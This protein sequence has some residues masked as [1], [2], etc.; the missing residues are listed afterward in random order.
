MSLILDSSSLANQIAGWTS[1]LV[2]IVFLRVIIRFG[3][4]ASVATVA[5][6]FAVAVAGTGAIAVAVVVART[7]A[8]AVAGV[9][10]IAGTFAIAGAFA[11][12]VAVAFAIARAFAVAGVFV[13]AVAFAIVG[14]FAVAGGYAV[15]FAIVFAVVFFLVGTYIAWRALQGEEKF[16]SIRNF[17]IAIAAFQGTSFHN[18][19]LTD[20]NFSQATLKSTNFCK[21]KLTRTCLQKVKML[22]RVRAGTT[23]LKHAKLRQVLITG[24]GQEKKFDNF[25]LR[26]VNLKGANL[27]DASFVS[28]DLS[29]ANLQDADL[30]RAKLVKT[31]LDGT[32]FTGST[33]T[34]AYIEDWGIT[35]KTK[36][37]GVKCEY[38]YMKLPTKDNPDPLRKPDNRQEV[39]ADGEFGDF[40][41]PIFDTLDLYHNHGV[42]PRAIAISLKQLA[43]DNPQ[44]ELQIVG[45]E[46]KGENNFLLRAK[47]A[48][49]TDKSE[50]SAKYFETYNQLKNLPAQ[51]MKLLLAEQ[52]SRIVNLENMVQTALYSSHYYAVKTILILAANPKT[53]SSLRLDEE[54]REIDAGLQR[55]KK[56]EQFDLKQRWAVRIRDVSQA[57]LDFKPRIVHFSGHG[58]GDDGLVLEDEMGNVQLVDGEA[59][60]ELFKLFADHVECVLLNACYSEVQALAIVKYIPYVIGMNWAIGDKASIEFAVGFYSAL[61]AGE[62]IEFAYQFGCS[63]IRLVGYR[64]HL[65]PVL[66]KKQ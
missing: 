22:D 17:A 7:F 57:L 2:L 59:L 27:A 58:S 5:G 30:S 49:N 15:A 20:A 42:D 19:D 11:V 56:R 44:A 43:E 28:A 10:A 63:A 29:E 32:D 21:A 26:E 35:N 62:S 40:I 34:G 50:L 13:F 66:K 31:Q 37:T 46:V 12:A 55:A 9:F 41:K 51:E 4:E 25:D 65:T 45:M 60:A 6:A 36:F 23:Y 39:F 52:D 47:T 61:G 18:A 38:V 48:P 54:V 1:L 8:I 24:Q 16:A 53:T 33:L 3:I 14:A 64:E